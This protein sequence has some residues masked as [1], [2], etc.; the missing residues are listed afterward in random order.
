MCC[1]VSM[2]VAAIQKPSKH[3]RLAYCWFNDGPSSATLD[4][5]RTSNGSASLVC[6][7]FTHL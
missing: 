2:F 6:L 3:E 1:S 4:Q 5:H 7:D